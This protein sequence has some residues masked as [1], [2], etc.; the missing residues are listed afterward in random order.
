[1]PRSTVGRLV[2]ISCV[3][4]SV[5]SA[6]G[7]QDRTGESTVPQALLGEFVDDY[8][9]RYVVSEEHW[10]QGEY[11]RY[12]IA[13]W[14]AEERFLIGRND[15]ENRTDAGL[16]TRIDWVL[17]E[18]GT[19]FEWAFCYA[20]YD[21]ESAEAARTRSPSDR[22]APRTGCNGFPFSRMRRT[23]LHRP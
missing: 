20:V 13:E 21:A 16:W 15:A 11:A 1:M 22:E 18:P 23:P 14:N 8:G 5:L 2:V 12:A 4:L 7:A 19:D 17:L 6:T 9:V 10:R 3:V